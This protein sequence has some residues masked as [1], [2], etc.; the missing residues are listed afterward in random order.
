MLFRT[1]SPA[2]KPSS[3]CRLEGI[4]ALVLE[5]RRIR[6]D[7]RRWCGS[8][9]GP[10]GPPQESPGWKPWEMETQIPGSPVRTPHPSI[11]RT[12]SLP[13]STELLGRLNPKYFLWSLQRSQLPTCDGLPPEAEATQRQTA[14]RSRQA[15]FRNCQRYGQNLYFQLCLNENSGTSKTNGIDM[16]RQAVK[17]Q[18]IDA[19]QWM[20]WADHD[21]LSAR[22]LLLSGLLVQG[23]AFSSTAIEKYLKCILTISGATVPR[24]HNVMNLYSEVKK[25][26]SAPALNDSYLQTL[27]KSYLLRYPDDLDKGFNISL[28]QKQLL[29]ELDRSVQR[30]RAGLRVRKNDGSAVETKFDLLLRK[31]DPRLTEHDIGVTAVTADEVFANP[32]ECY[33]LRVLTDRGILE[34]SYQAD[35]KGDGRLRT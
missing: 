12:L 24:T 17:Q 5:Y 3:V 32:S 14:P 4:E 6:S 19:L 33:E 23:C 8:A 1:M 20:T 13:T 18:A 29:V 35:V 11:T 34:A 10:I 15:V 30:I 31:N 25:R 27:V 7:S 16:Q 22:T 9:R 26:G 2:A 21:Y 28:A